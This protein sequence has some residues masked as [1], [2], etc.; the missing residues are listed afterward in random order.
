MGNVINQHN[1]EIRDIMQRAL[2]GEMNEADATRTI[3]LL[4]R[5]LI[6]YLLNAPLTER[7]AGLM[8][9]TSVLL[10]KAA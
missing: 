6:A 7:P 1:E 4:Q 10:Q 8:E 9:E 3:I 2:N 5:E